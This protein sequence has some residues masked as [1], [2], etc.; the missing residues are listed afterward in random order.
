MPPRQYRALVRQQDLDW[1]QARLMAD[2][3]VQN[4]AWRQQGLNGSKQSSDQG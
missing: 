2:G 3:F 1:H 4:S